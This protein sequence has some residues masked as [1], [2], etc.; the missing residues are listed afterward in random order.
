MKT[1][2]TKKETKSGVRFIAITP[3]EWKEAKPLLEADWQTWKDWYDSD[4]IEMHIKNCGFGII[5]EKT[6]TAIDN[7]FD[8]DEIYSMLK[9]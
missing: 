8:L 6:L 4:L 7:E 5:D 1:I 9:N 2:G 3:D